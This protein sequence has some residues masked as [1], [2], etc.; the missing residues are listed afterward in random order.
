[1]NTRMLAVFAALAVAM[2][3]VAS[4]QRRAVATPGANRTI[5]TPAYRAGYERG[6]RGG[7]D[8]GRRN[9]A[10]SYANRSD[11]RS[12]D[13]GY[14]REFGDRDRY[15]SEFRRGFEVGYRDGFARYRP[16]YGRNDGW[17]PGRGGPPPW[18]TARGRGGYQRTDYAFRIGF[19]DG[20][21]AGLRDARDRRRFDPIGEGR[22]RSGD[23][24]YNRSYG[25]RDDYRLRYR[26]A[27]SEGYEHG[28]DDGWRYAERVN[29]RPWW[30][31]W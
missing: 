19:T 6:I 5:E 21:E 14:R 9:Q 4:A 26:G 27:F 12:G 16:G 25:T 3:V 10:Y 28:F 11:Y 15:R 29:D 22:Y 7:E 30:W 23:H 18:A 20:Y 1:M 24:G 8:D 2:P 31:P 13:S 17:R